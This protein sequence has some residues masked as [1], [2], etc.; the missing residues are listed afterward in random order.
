M[1]Q[2]KLNTFI[3]L[4][5]KVQKQ[6]NRTFDLG[7]IVKEPKSKMSSVKILEEIKKIAT[8]EKI[9]YDKLS[10][11]EDVIENLVNI[12]EKDKWVF[13]E[14]KKDIGSPLLNQLKHLANYNSFQLI[15]Y[16]EKDV[17]EM[18]MPKNSRLIVFAERDFIENKITYT[19][20]Y[21][22]FGPTL[23]L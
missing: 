12:F 10:V 18:K 1:E 14:I 5:Q 21:R 2:E 23:S 22:L 17:F 16:K 6:P 13:L 4:L 7:L 11:D 3:R 19:H 15:D 9:T 8:I 20:F